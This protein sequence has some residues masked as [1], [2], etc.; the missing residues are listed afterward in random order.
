[1]ENSEKATHS[2]SPFDRADPDS[3]PESAAIDEFLEA[4]GEVGDLSAFCNRHGDASGELKRR[5]EAL[6]WLVAPKAKNK[7]TTADAV[8][9]DLPFERLGEFRLIRRLGEG[10][11]GV[12]FLARQESLGRLVA[13]KTLRQERVG[14]AES[15]ERFIRE[16][17]AIASIRHPS[18]V[19][20]FASGKDR[21][22]AYIAMEYLDGSGLDELLSEAARRNEYIPI[23]RVVRWCLEIARA[24]DCAHAAGIIHRDI[25]PSNI[26]IDKQDG[27]RLT[28]FGLARFDDDV[29]LTVTGGFLGSPRYA[30]PEQIGGDR[31]MISLK[32]DI[33]SLGITL[34]ECV[35]GRTPFD[36]SSTD[37]LY[38][39]IRT[40]NIPS[41]RLVNR[42]IPRDLETV[43]LKAIETDTDRRYE[44]AAAF[45]KDL[46]AVLELRPIAAR[47][48][49][50]LR[51]M[52]LWG[53]R[54]PKLILVAIAIAVAAASATAIF[55]LQ[56]SGDRILEIKQ[57]IGELDSLNE[58]F[59]HIVN[60]WTVVE[61][62]A[63]L[64][65]ST[66]ENAYV[67]PR[68]VAALEKDL[69]GIRDV[70][71]ER[72]VVS[73]RIQSVLALLERY[74]PG[75]DSLRLA[76][77]RFFKTKNDEALR[78]KDPESAE[79]YKKLVQSLDPGGYYG[80]S[81][82]SDQDFTI[83]TNP[84]NAEVYFFR[85]CE[86]D[87]IDPS[88]PA[89]FAPVPSIHA[90]QAVKPGTW[91]LR[92]VR[93]A[94]ELREHDLI[95]KIAGNSVENSVFVDNDAGE[96]KRFDRLSGVDGQPVNNITDWKSIIINP[97][98]ID[99]I[100][101]THAVSIARG[102]QN[103]EKRLK[104]GD[105]LSL[106]IVDPRTLA[107]E[108][109]AEAEV[110]H[111]GNLARMVLPGGLRV[112]A[113]AAPLIITKDNLIGRTPLMLKEVDAS[114]VLCLMRR[115]GFEDQ[116]ANLD[117]NNRKLI[118][119]ELLPIGTSPD[120]Y[121]YIGGRGY[122][123]QEREVTSGEYLQFLNDPATL[124]EI[125]TSSNPTR[126]PRARDLGSLWKRAPSGEFELPPEWE[127]TYP[128]AGVS[129]HD[130]MAYAGW[131]T[132]K[133]KKKGE[134]F[135]YTL[136]SADN[137]LRAHQIDRSTYIFGNQFRPGWTKS[138][139]SKKRPCMEPVM[140]YPIDESA[141][142]IYDLVG[143]VREYSEGWFWPERKEH[144][145][146]G[147]SWLQGNPQS[148]KTGAVIGLGEDQTLEDS[149]F[150]LVA[151]RV[152]S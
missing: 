124:R 28:D 22:I 26:R 3:D 2:D 29:T 58:R 96:L 42:N 37:A 141:F 39:N 136:P 49:T 134:R 34:Y 121:V 91:A 104:T 137:R 75:A 112:R 24:L 102:G 97:E 32:S 114:Y 147:G 13:L 64:L 8:D 70:Q 145:L 84:A 98:I 80:N 107:E 77:A 55:Q 33:Y 25:K 76:K 38:V 125:D 65:Q 47:P 43:I 150:R 56:R 117:S 15:E 9:A 108:G 152:R 87:E 31:E 27:A 99:N 36:E 53:R 4:A 17:R 143:G 122:W 81:F 105:L 50:R 128:V 95:T 5:L 83:I 140:S 40:G 79:Y 138:C 109:G 92:V 61:D 1:M 14:S 6:R 71:R 7:T 51:K 12:V 45:A 11:M 44:S 72:D 52:Q 116:L 106:K 69:A 54:N 119:T 21:G 35:A 151:K 133:A 94:S 130:A 127:F 148:F 126:F 48:P 113:T 46:E 115:D 82:H 57:L 60:S 120:G 74:D 131:L 101:N 118:D 88:F 89:R 78:R 111:S 144:P 63:R 86:L 146:E 73:A 90:M 139:F 129:Y 20:V 67:D 19:P 142:G 93:G 59:E 85:V 68:D 23:A 66:V 16:A 110:Y 30:S 41:P 100:A 132:E 123:M 149:G 18:V 103:L 62:K 10:G 135:E